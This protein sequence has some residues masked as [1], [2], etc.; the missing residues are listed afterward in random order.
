MFQLFM[1]IFA[2]MLEMF[3]MILLN[4]V[5]IFSIFCAFVVCYALIRFFM[6]YSPGGGDK[7]E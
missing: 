5:P 3:S 7:E 6:S 2:G 4:G 1:Q